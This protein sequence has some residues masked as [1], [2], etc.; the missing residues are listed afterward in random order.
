MIM[1]GL[2]DGAHGT[3]TLRAQ[4]VIRPHPSHEW[5]NH[6]NHRWI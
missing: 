2:A 6:K 5:A 4:S 1:L 3:T